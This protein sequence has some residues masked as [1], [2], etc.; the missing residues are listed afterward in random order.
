MGFGLFTAIKGGVSVLL[1]V[2]LSLLA[3]RVG[4][5]AAGVLSGYP[6]GAALSLF[7]I[8]VEIDPAFAAR[9]AVFTAGGLTATLAFAAGY[10]MGLRGAEKRHR[11]AAMALTILS[12]L[13]AYGAAAA[14][15]AAIPLHW[16][17]AP[18]VAVV[19]LFLAERAFRGVPDAG[20][21]PKT[22]FR[23][24]VAL[25]RG[26]FAAL[27]IVA[28]TAAAQAVGPEWAGLFSAFPVTMLPLLAIVQFSQPPAQVRT[29]LKNVPRGLGSLLVYVLVVAAAYPTLGVGLGTLLAYAAAT[30]Y[31][32]AIESLRRRLRKA[33]P[34][35]VNIQRT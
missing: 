11:I 15:L 4:P 9:S 20:L 22:P 14:V 31:L 25:V 1:V 33:S 28:I 6:M 8:G 18:A 16:F 19:G 29:I 7:F 23:L 30:G 26:A 10:L 27:A 12:A 32:V 13:I 5:R 34:I 17:S 35:P 3:E 24:S 21:P 2:G